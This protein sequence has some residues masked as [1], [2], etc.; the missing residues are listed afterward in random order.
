MDSK[1]IPHPHREMA[2]VFKYKLHNNNKYAPIRAT[3][4]SAGYD[5]FAPKTLTLPKDGEELF[6][7]DLSI[8]M[9]SGFFGL[10]TSRSSMEL[11]GIV[12]SLGII[13]SDYTGLFK[14][15]VKNYSGAEIT[16]HEGERFCQ[17]VLISLLPVKMISEDSIENS[18]FAVGSLIKD[19]EPKTIRTGG[20]GSTGNAT[21]ID[22]NETKLYSQLGE[23]ET[24]RCPQ[25]KGFYNT[26]ACVCSYGNIERKSLN[27]RCPLCNGYLSPFAFN[28]SFKHN[29][30]QY[31]RSCYMEKLKETE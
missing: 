28:D 12:T 10:L 3:S 1:W 24:K 6:S 14:A 9:P 27:Q 18:E 25:C 8:S 23:T 21:S 5:I 13:D 29:G 16:I 4:N 11:K 26:Y 22:Q 30:L 2:I 31:H 17:L 15:H 19:L 7:L 20:W